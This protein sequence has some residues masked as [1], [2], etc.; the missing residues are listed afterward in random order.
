MI[1]WTLIRRFRIATRRDR[2]SG[3]ITIMET[4]IAISVGAVALFTWAQF[5]AT[6]LE[7]DA[8]KT[9]GRNVA[10]Y[11]RATAAWLADSPPA[12]PGDYDI[13]NLQD[14]SDPNGVR[15]LPCV[16][17]ADT[18]IGL[19]TDDQGTPLEF[20]DLRIAV[21]LPVE[22]P[23]A[24]VDLGVFRKG[25][26][27]NGDGL[28]DSRPDLAAIA[29]QHAREETAPAVFGFFELAFAREDPTGLV[30]D[31]TNSA[32]DQVEVDNLARVIAHAGAHL[33][34]A[35]FLRTDGSNDMT[36]AIGFDNGVSLSPVGNTLEVAASGGINF[37]TDVTLQDV[38][39][40]GIETETVK[41][42]DTLTVT[43]AD[44]VLGA[45][46]YRLDQSADIV[47][48]D[49][50]VVRLTARVARNETDIAA[51]DADIAAN[52]ADI[53]TNETNIATHAANIAT[54]ASN[55]SV[56][57]NNIAA[58]TSR[59]SSNISDIATNAANIAANTS[60]ISANASAIGNRR[61]EII[62]NRTQIN[63]IKT[64]I[65]NQPPA[66]CSPT[67]AAAI[68]AAGGGSTSCASVLGCERQCQVRTRVS[69]KLVS[70][71]TRNLTTLKCDSHSVLLYTSCCI[72]RGQYGGN[73]DGICA[74]GFYE[75]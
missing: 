38:T 68:A 72:E 12:T 61:T 39:A 19:A 62:N 9:A 54:N 73:C 16:Y 27:D 34:A 59:I 60:R 42:S 6:A 46:F 22:G 25:S 8:A 65:N 64:I 26:D 56:N 70:Y 52:A 75:C 31:T 29:V 4:L 69:S 10:A 32:Y 41:V 44:G 48:I 66:V 18:V 5:Q 14:C 11:A 24:T 71:K 47:R 53:A 57:A 63:N 45:G 28:S 51:N 74:S 15:F 43:E 37:N 50:D 3:A 67:R 23:R 17:D 7:A 1:D 13:T 33:T 49:G 40:Q 55:I 30:F 35:P 36:A 21:R 2:Q 58:N 20:G